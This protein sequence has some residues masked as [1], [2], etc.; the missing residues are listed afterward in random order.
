MVAIYTLRYWLAV[1]Y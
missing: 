1:K